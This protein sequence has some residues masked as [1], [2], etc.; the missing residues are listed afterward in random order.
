MQV[1]G[2]LEYFH[3]IEGAKKATVLQQPLVQADDARLDVILLN[4]NITAISRN[5]MTTAAFSPF[6]LIAPECTIDSTND[7]WA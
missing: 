1:P 5:K 3:P 2:V 7:I 4:K 6:L